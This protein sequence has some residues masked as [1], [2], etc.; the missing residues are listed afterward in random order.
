MGGWL[1]RTVYNPNNYNCAAVNN[2]NVN[3]C[4]NNSSPQGQVFYADIGST[5][6]PPVYNL[7]A[8]NLCHG[9][10]GVAGGHVGTDTGQAG[11]DKIKVD[12]AGANLSGGQCFHRTH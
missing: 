1:C 2:N 6:S 9:A 3:Y 7:W 8:V 12:M 11:F 5:N 4:P 10:E